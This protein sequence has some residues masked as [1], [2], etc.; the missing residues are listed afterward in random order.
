MAKRYQPLLP[1]LL[2]LLQHSAVLGQ[3]SC[4]DSKNSVD[5]DGNKVPIRGV[6]VNDPYYNSFTK[7]IYVVDGTK[8]GD[9]TWAK[10]QDFCY[11]QFKSPDNRYAGYLASVHTSNE[12]TFINTEMLKAGK[13][14]NFWIGLRFTLLLYISRDLVIIIKESMPNM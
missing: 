1:L 7:C 11:E 5:L 6:I 3:S 2:Y 13:Y 8:F 14:W 10:A 12:A 9:R 4:P